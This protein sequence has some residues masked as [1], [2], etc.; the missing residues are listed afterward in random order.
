MLWVDFCASWY[1][2]GTDAIV[3]LLTEAVL[4]CGFLL[5]Q[6]STVELYRMPLGNLRQTH[7]WAYKCFVIL[8]KGYCA[9]ALS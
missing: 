7:P 3:Y 8:R 4:Y 9:T 6:V 2:A 1:I 5:Q